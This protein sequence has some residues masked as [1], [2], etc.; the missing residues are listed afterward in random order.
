MKHDTFQG[1]EESPSLFS[2]L[3]VWGSCWR[4][5]TEKEGRGNG[6]QLC[7]CLKRKQIFRSR[8]RGPQ[9]SG[10]NRPRVSVKGQL[11]DRHKKPFST[12]S[13]SAVPSGKLPLE[14]GHKLSDSHTFQGCGEHSF[15]FL[16]L[17]GHFRRELGELQ[18]ACNPDAISLL[19]TYAF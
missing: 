3:L 14:L 16:H 6:K 19:S 10:W 8:R 11:Y 13:T 12:A 15:L 4:W 1:R 18:Q 7:G 17:S 9:H 5:W 2:T